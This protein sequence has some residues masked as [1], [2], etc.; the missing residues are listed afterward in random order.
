MYGRAL[1][2]CCCALRVHDVPNNEPPRQA[3]RGLNR[4]PL[5]YLLLTELR[6]NGRYDDKNEGDDPMLQLALVNCVKCVRPWLL[7]V[8]TGAA[9]AMRVRRVF[10]GLCFVSDRSLTRHFAV[11]DVRTGTR[12]PYGGRW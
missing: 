3:V 5:A 6:W 1:P 11:C 7:T 8:V 9:R 4:F 12:V 2:R 10:R